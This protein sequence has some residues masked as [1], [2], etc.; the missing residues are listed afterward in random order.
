MT[1]V[2]RRFLEALALMPAVLLAAP[3]RAGALPLSFDEL[4]SGVSPLGL[5]FSDKLKEARGKS[6]VMQG[7]MAPPLKAEAKFFVLTQQPMALCP[8]CSSD[9]DWPDNIVVVY[10]NYPQT[11]VQSNAPIRVTG[12]LEVGSWRDP[13]TGFLSLVRLVG[14]SFR[15]V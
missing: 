13:E 10:L 11:F 3:A 14:A 15:T 1:L 4:Y 6:V 7:F 5:I 8:F 12:L 9:A 2:R